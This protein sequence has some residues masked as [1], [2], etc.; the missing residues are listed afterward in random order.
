LLAHIGNNGSIL[1]S[2]WRSSM[3]TSYLKSNFLDRTCRCYGTLHVL[4]L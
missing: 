4:I 2:Y 3:N 1:I